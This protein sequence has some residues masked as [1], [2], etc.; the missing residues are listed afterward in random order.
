MDTSHNHF[1]LKKT[2]QYFLKKKTSIF[3]KPILGIRRT[4]PRRPR[5]NRTKLSISDLFRLLPSF[6]A[7]HRLSRRF[8]PPAP[9]PTHLLPSLYLSISTNLA[10]CLPMLSVFFFCEKMTFFILFFVVSVAGT[11][12]FL[13]DLIGL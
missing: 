3:L 8:S 1:F 9:S 11:A 5:P 7:D 6:V 13:R 12:C 2:R 10:S 4:C